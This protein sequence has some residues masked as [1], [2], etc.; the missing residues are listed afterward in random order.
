MIAPQLAV[1][2]PRVVSPGS[3]EI[4]PVETVVADLLQQRERCILQIR[5]GPGCGMTTALR[6]LAAT[7]DSALSVQFL[8]EPPPAEVATLAASRSVVFT[9][10]LPLRIAHEQLVLAPWTEDDF[11]EYLMRVHPDQCATVLGRIRADP[12]RAALNGCPTVW[13]VVLDAFCGSDPPVSIRAAIE[14]TLQAILS[15]R[16][17]RR[18]AAEFSLAILQRNQR[19]AVRTF[20]LLARD[21]AACERYR[22][23]R[24]GFVQQLLAGNLVARQVATGGDC[25]ALQKPLPHPLVDELTRHTKA[26]SRLVLQLEEFIGRGSNDVKPQAATILFAANPR[27]RPADYRPATLTGGT[28]RDAAWSGLQLSVGC[29]GPSS[30]EYADL[31]GADLREAVLDGAA[32]RA[33]QLAGA[34]LDKASLVGLDA[35]QANLRGASLI[36]A[37]ADRIQLHGA[38]LQNAVLDDISLV[39]ADLETANL[40]GARFRNAMLCFSNLRGCQLAGTDFR[41]ARLD[42]CCL[43]LLV[44]RDAELQGA[45]FPEADLTECDLEGVRLEGSDFRKAR[46]YRALLT[47]SVIPDADFREANLREAGLAEIHWENADLRGADLRGCTFHMGSTRCGLVGSPYPGHGSKTGFYTDDY[48]DQSYK[49]AETIRKANLCGADLR[50]AR[51]DGVDFYLVDLRGTRFDGAAEEQLIQCGAILKDRHD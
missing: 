28:F 26:D 45:S 19:E 9:G 14:S 11:I 25:P 16:G 47:G 40:R 36:A 42:G 30:L 1:V 35:W 43:R 33:A 15:R 5:G 24:H 37:N 2:R 18:L 46:L 8:D 29:G 12:E 48:H 4:L 23:L 3:G 34:C 50:G 20:G 44:L 32:A 51:L 17:Q 31:T 49:E 6:H 41:N 38:L 10:R 7:I 13:R 27:W 39:G 22:V 21:E